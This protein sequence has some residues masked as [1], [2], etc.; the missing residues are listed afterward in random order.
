MFDHEKLSIA[1]RMK[2]GERSLQKAA[3]E[4]GDISA[5]TLHRIER[6]EQRPDLDTYAKLCDWMGVPMS[7]FRA[8]SH[9]KAAA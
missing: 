1:L 7:Y 2:R 6:G 9:E 5:T 3:D 4:I 8:S